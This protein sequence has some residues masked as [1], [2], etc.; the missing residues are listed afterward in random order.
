MLSPA[1]LVT[2]AGTVYGQNPDQ[3]DIFRAA[4]VTPNIL[5]LL[6]TSCSMGDIIQPFT[7]CPQ[8]VVDY[9][10]A[11]M[12]QL[13]K[14][15]QLQAVLA[16]CTSQTDGLIHQW[17]SRV[18]FGM[19]EFTSGQIQLDAEF[20]STENQLVTAALNLGHISGTPMT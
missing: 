4:D 7:D 19:M 2:L 5:L 18:N 6:D 1:L 14:Y 11:S 17:S 10:P 3:L 9:A 15:Q 13:A 12:G 16:E 8:Y 20:G